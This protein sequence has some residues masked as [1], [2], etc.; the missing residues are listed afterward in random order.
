MARRRSPS[1][2][3]INAVKACVGQRC[4]HARKRATH[5]LAT[6]DRLLFAYVLQPAA[7]V[8]DVKRLESEF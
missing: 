5:V 1:D 3:L 6:F 4:D 2:V 8:G 7:R